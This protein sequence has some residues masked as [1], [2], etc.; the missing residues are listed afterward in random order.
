MLLS[1]DKEAAL[2]RPNVKLLVGTDPLVVVLAFP[3]TL[4][5][6]GETDDPPPWGACVLVELAN[7]LTVSLLL[8]TEDPLDPFMLLSVIDFAGPVAKSWS[9]PKCESLLP[10]AG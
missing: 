7:G 8:L 1:P 2:L 9:T 3:C 10:V 4:V 6:P 5:T